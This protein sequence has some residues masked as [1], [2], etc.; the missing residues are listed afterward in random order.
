MPPLNSEIYLYGPMVLRDEDES[1]LFTTLF[2][3]KY[4]VLLFVLIFI[5]MVSCS[6]LVLF[7]VNTFY[8]SEIKINS[9]KSVCV[10]THSGK[11]FNLSVGRSRVFLFCNVRTFF[12]QSKIKDKILSLC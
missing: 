5:F 4:F 7:S 8:N 11:F 6:E 9:K 10:F 2:S 12:V 1:F 3:S